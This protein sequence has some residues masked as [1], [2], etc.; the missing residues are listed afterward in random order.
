MQKDCRKQECKLQ[1]QT[2]VQEGHYERDYVVQV[3]GILVQL[4]WEAELQENA[5]F[6]LT[7]DSLWEM[8]SAVRGRMKQHWKHLLHFD[9]IVGVKYELCRQSTLEI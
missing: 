5:D 6:T 9:W 1:T 3:N 8:V 4:F 2:S 7:S